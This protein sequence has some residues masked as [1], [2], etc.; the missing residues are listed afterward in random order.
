L[1]VAIVHYWL[2][3]WRGGEKVLKEIA[4]LFPQADIYTHVADKDLLA[5]ELPGRRVFTTF[6]DRLP[7]ARRLY[8]KY[9][10]FMPMALEQLDLREYDLVISCEAGPAKGVIVSPH[11]THICYCHS[12]MRYVWDMYHEYRSRTGAVTRVLMAP[13]LHR[14]RIWDQLSAQRV[15]HFVANS[16]FVARRIS[17][18]YR[19]E[20]EVVYPPVAV[21]EFEASARPGEFFLWVGQLIGYKRPDLMIEAFNQL[22]LPLV[23]IGD[24]A[25]LPELRKKAKANV[26]LLGRQSSEVIREHYARCRAVVFPGVEDFGIVPVEAMAS[27]RPVIAYG[28]G[29]AMETVVDGVTGMLFQEQTVDGLIRA[30]RDFADREREFDPVRIRAHAARFSPQRFNSSFRALVDQWAGA[31]GG[32]HKPVPCAAQAV[33]ADHQDLDV[34]A[35]QTV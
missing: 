4:G 9:L 26:Q 20:A 15:D 1:R 13:L 16:Q 23:V 12:P 29:G 24:G 21:D 35:R 33:A 14:L 11:A 28:A 7:L 10:P 27:G 19:R 6:I 22:K 25:M 5:R 2:V 30:V 31:G 34:E 8:Q 32:S 18:Y 17:K 3:N